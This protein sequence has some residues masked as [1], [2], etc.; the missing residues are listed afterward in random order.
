MTAVGLSPIE[1][2][3]KQ[4]YLSADIRIQTCMYMSYCTGSVTYL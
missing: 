3:Y 4:K 1:Q 2:V